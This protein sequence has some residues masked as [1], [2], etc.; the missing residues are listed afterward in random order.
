MITGISKTIT[1]GRSAT[2]GS[3]GVSWGSSCPSGAGWSLAVLLS[4]VV[5][6]TSLHLPRL[7]QVGMDRYII[8]ADLGLDERLSGLTELG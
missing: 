4:F 8:G 2:S 3:G 5:T 6:A 7:I 1:S